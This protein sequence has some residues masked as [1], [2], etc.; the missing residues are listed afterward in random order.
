[1]A[2]PASPNRYTCVAGEVEDAN[3][4]NKSHATDRDVRAQ[5]VPSLAET[6]STELFILFTQGMMGGRM[7]GSLVGSIFRA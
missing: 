2:S 1:M 4:H 6:C 5:G 3:V 7:S